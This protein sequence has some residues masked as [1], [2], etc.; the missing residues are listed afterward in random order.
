MA[1]I[2]F[3]TLK[4]EV[5]K[6]IKK[7]QNLKDL[8]EIFRK[9]LGKNGQIA[10]ILHSLEKLSKTKRAKIG[11]TTNELK[12]FLM[13][14]FEKRA[15][16]LKEKIEKEVERK[17]WIDITIPGKKPISGHLH[18]LTQVKR[19]VEEIFQSMGFSVVE[20]LEVENE[21]YNFDALNIP[22]DH[23]ARDAWDTFWLKPENQKSKIKN[24]KLLLRT[25]TSP[26]QVRYM[27]SHNP[28]LRIIVPGNVFRHEATDARHEFQLS[29]IEGLMVDKE[30]S[31]VHLKA[32]L[33]EFFK[34]FFGK[35]TA[36]RLDP[37]FFPFTEPSFSI[38]IT[39]AICEGKGCNICKKTGWL[40]MAGAGMVHPSVFK[41]SKLIPHQRSGL[42]WRG[43]AFGF[44]L[45][46]LAMMK[47]RIDDIRLFRSGDLRFLNQF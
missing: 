1:K 19:E 15:Q 20:G 6:E 3:K 36:F 32:I 27:E 23:P 39:C 8:D 25:H 5:E 29:Q 11:K 13:A 31:V 40:E 17:E 30:I 24:Q 33:T 42:G 35:N 46:R 10:Q 4:I 45:D 12:N 22:K 2:N 9:Y 21:W 7:S 38:S 16:K 43:W 26:V 47:Y 34:R 37:D 41:Y 44:G 14:E 28:P 18:P